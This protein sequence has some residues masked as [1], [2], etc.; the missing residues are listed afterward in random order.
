MFLISISVAF[1]ADVNGVRGS[2]WG[3]TFITVM[4]NENMLGG[5]LLQKGVNS[6]GLFEFQYE[7]PMQMGPAMSYY[8]FDK[9][10]KLANGGVVILMKNTDIN[11]F[12]IYYRNYQAIKD[13]LKEY[14]KSHPVLD[15][16][17]E[18]QVI[19]NSI[20]QSCERQKDWM[21]E[22]IAFK[23]VKLQNEFLSANNHTS[24]KIWGKDDFG[25]NIHIHYTPAM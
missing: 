13:F 3:S 24:I 25:A 5:K 11:D 6:D 10:D 18:I 2:K 19:D 8:V 9:K 23:K 16:C 17:E 7:F 21:G 22:L 1:A 14:L 15:T 4:D 20:V 12:N